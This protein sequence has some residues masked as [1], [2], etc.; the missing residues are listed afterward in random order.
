MPLDKKRKN[1]Q[2]WTRL[3]D[4]IRQLINSKQG[5]A[6]IRYAITLLI[7]VISFNVFNVINSYVGRDF[8]S[9]IE[10][11]NVTAFYTNAILYAIVFIISSG[12]GS[13]NRYAE[14]RLGILWRE[15][16]TWKFTEN[17]LTERTFQK[18]HWWP[19]H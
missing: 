18:N 7:L 14:E 11:K 15:Q 6:A 2:N 1:S 12:I 3:T 17:Y 13:I 10:Q 16:L 4:K 5:P 9:S 19:W 8:I